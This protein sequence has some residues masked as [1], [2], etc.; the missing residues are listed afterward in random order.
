[1]FYYVMEYLPGMSFEE[2]VQTQDRQPAA[3]VVHLLRQAC[4]A[5]GEA[6][7][8]GL[9][10]RDIKPANLFVAQR[11]GV[12][13]VVKVLDFGL[14]KQIGETPSARLTQEGSLSGTPLYMSPEQASGIGDVDGRSDIYSLG[15]V[16]YMLLTGRAPFEGR[17]TM[18]VLIAHAR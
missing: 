17:S 1:M 9:I 5:L 12:Y 18:E 3:R 2:M 16:A 13:D 14:V 8:I 6:H 4:Q 10:H 7:S 11:G 15:A